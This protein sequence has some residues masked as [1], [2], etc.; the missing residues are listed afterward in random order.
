LPGKLPEDMA[1]TD[2]HYE[3]CRILSRE[4]KHTVIYSTEY[5]CWLVSHFQFTQYKLL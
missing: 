1:Y 2:M 3:R 4:Y 5:C